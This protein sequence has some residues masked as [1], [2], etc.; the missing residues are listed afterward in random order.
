MPGA[1]PGALLATVDTLSQRTLETL[2]RLDTAPRLVVTHHRAHA[3]GLGNG[4]P[5]RDVSLGLN[6]ATEPEQILRLCI[7]AGRFDA[8]DLD[9]RPATRP[10]SSGLTL[11]RLAGL[12]P[13]ILGVSVNGRG[14]G[15][16]GSGWPAARSSP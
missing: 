14:A 8:P 4:G 12:L 3:M 9:P 1:K 13:A 10:E 6:G 15:G 5:S 2:G 11:A 16:L 7:A